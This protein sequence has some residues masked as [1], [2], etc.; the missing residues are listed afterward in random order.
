MRR[1]GWGVHKR[2][3]SRVFH[4]YLFS[5]WEYG[6]ESEQ[7]SQQ[8]ACYRAQDETGGLDMEQRWE[9]YLP[10]WPICFSGRPSWQ[11]P[12][13]S[14]LELGATI[15]GW[16]VRKVGRVG[17]CD[18]LEIEVINEGEATLGSATELGIRPG[19]WIWRGRGIDEVL[20]LADMILWP[21]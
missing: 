20:E 2:N 17:L 18:P 4:Q 21:E 15:T 7:K 3:E 11:V 9:M 19:G 6:E 8:I 1:K 14:L 13:E 12:R 16:V 5:P 10:C